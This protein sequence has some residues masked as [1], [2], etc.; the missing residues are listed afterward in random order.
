MGWGG[1]M[2]VRTFR[3]LVLV[4]RHEMYLPW[5]ERSCPCVPFQVT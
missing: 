5:K 1:G 3:G 4:P 2:P